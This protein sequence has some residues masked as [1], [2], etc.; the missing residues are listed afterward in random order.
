MRKSELAELTDGCRLPPEQLGEGRVRYRLKGKVIKGRKLGGEH[1]QWVTIKQAHDT[2][3][4]AASLADPVK[5]DGHLFKS[6]SFFTP[7]EWFLTWVNGSDGRRLGL[8]PIP[9]VPVS[10]R[11]LRRT[12]AVEM[13]HRPGG[14]LAAKIHLKHISVVT[15]EGYADRPGGAQSVLMAEFGQEEREHKMRVAL[16]A[17]H[18]YRNGIRPAGPGASDLLDFFAFVDEQLDSSGAPNIKRSDQEVTNLLAKRAKALH[19]GPANYCWFLDPSKALCLKL[20]G[21]HARGATE[22]LIGMC[23]S[24]RCPQATH[25]AGH[26]PV[27]AASADSKKVF[28]ATIG[29]EQRTEKTRLR[30]E[31]AR[32]ERVLAEIDALSGTGA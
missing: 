31:L 5:S 22:P 26:R 15:T 3:G 1:D 4:V 20:A 6:L 11:M 12:L 30:T 2:A 17:F 18:D 28:I 13:A 19:L 32:D 21:T 23:D 14:L 9:E 10:L 29:R 24:A 7:Y 27:W 25:H 16:D 8:A